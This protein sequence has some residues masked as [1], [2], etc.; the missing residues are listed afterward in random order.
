MGWRT[1]SGGIIV[2]RQGPISGGQMVDFLKAFCE[3]GL[4]LRIRRD[5]RAQ[6]EGIEPFA[7]YGILRAD[8]EEELK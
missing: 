4:V 1:G 5:P 7:I 6:R 3:G 2:P 8:S